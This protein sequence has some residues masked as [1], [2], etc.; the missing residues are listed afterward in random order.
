M[1]DSIN[2]RDLSDERPD[3]ARLEEWAGRSG[4][5]TD[6]MRMGAASLVYSPGCK[7]VTIDDLERFARTVIAAD[8][9][10]R[11][12][13]AE[14][15]RLECV[16]CGGRCFCGRAYRIPPQPDAERV[17]HSQGP[18]KGVDDA[19][20]AMWPGCGCKLQADCAVA[21]PAH[22]QAGD[23]AAFERWV[24]KYPVLIVGDLYDYCFD[25]FKAARALPLDAGRVAELERENERLNTLLLDMETSK[26]AA[27]AQLAEARDLV[28]SLRDELNRHGYVVTMPAGWDDAARTKAQGEPT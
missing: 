26:D 4:M 12:A 11:A 21:A 14:R 10:L 23:E 7:G 9:A 15:E 3:I 8:R 20:C 2:D 28:Q 6:L 16:V 25:A 18:I 13:P 24:D 5:Y 17:A 19:P 1:P 27:L 22:S